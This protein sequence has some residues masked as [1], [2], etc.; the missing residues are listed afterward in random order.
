MMSWRWLKNPPGGIKAV[1]LVAAIIAY[2]TSGFMYFEIDDRP[3]LQWADALW[4]SVVTMT[5]V[6]FGDWFPL[7]LP[8]KM[9]VGL[10]V[11]DTHG[12]PPGAARALSRS[13]L[14]LLGLAFLGLGAVPIFLDPARRAAHDRLVGTRVI[15][16]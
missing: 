3:E 1:I 15:R 7:T 16:P 4:W 8:G 10:R 14:A 5:T 13:I 6:G 2:G 12:N 11:V 9:L